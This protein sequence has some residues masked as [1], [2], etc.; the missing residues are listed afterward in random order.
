MQVERVN[1][2]ITGEKLCFKFNYPKKFLCCISLETGVLALALYTVLANIAHIGVVSYFI[3]RGA[4]V[5]NFGE[6]VDGS[7]GEVYRITIIFYIFKKTTEDWDTEVK[8]KAGFL[9]FSLISLLMNIIGLVGV[10]KRKPILVYILCCG[11][12]LC[13]GLW[14]ITILDKAFESNDFTIPTGL[15]WTLTIIASVI[16]ILFS[17]YF[18]ICVYSLYLKLRK[19]EKEGQVRQNLLLV[20]DMY[21]EN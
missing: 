5:T 9:A 13:H 1:M 8:W 21:Q 3:S 10:Q 4:D 7:K 18:A 17:F 19:E 20:L 15:V 2:C 12:G 14:A 11:V 6:L 16:A